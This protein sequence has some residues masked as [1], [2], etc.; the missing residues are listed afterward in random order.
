MHIFLIRKD[1]Y[2][3]LRY[4][5]PEESVGGEL[6]YND[7]VHVNT[8]T[9]LSMMMVRVD[10]RKSHPAKIFSTI[11]YSWLLRQENVFQKKVLLFKMF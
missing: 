8:S 5:L 3:L 7:L 6:E 4:F 9:D 10:F 11:A 1:F 2:F